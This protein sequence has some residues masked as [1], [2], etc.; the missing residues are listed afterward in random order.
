LNPATLSLQPP[1][2]FQQETM[3]FSFLKNGCHANHNAVGMDVAI[4]G[5]RFKRSRVNA[6]VNQTDLFRRY[7]CLDQQLRNSLRYCNHPIDLSIVKTPGVPVARLRIIHSPG[8]HAF[9]GVRDSQNEKVRL[10]V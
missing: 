8:H 10:L 2:R 6:V 4:I 1:R 9:F 3:T 7:P 5:R